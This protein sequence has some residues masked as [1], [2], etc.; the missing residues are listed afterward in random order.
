MSA[1]RFVF[2]NSR[3]YQEGQTITEGPIV[4]EIT[5]DGVILSNHGQRFML[6]RQ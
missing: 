1:G 6:P 2:I 4:E 5:P 3:K